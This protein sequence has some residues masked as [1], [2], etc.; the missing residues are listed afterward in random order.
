MPIHTPW[1]P[2]LT[3][4]GR[5]HALAMQCESIVARV[6]LADPSRS[7]WPIEFHRAAVQACNEAGARRWYGR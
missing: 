1:A 4:A 6:A 2:V 5:E 7:D 3:D